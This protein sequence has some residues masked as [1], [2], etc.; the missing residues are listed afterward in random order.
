MDNFK[1][2]SSKFKT[3]LIQ[4][5]YAKKTYQEALDFVKETKRS[6]S[7]DDIHLRNICKDVISEIKKD[8]LAQHLLD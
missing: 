7:H 6:L 2:E 5:A 3:K 8:A 4:K 1:D